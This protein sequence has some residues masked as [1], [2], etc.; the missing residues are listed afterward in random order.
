[1]HI[2][3]SSP[4]QIAQPYTNIQPLIYMYISLTSPGQ[5]AQPHIIDQ[6][7]SLANNYMLPRIESFNITESQNSFILNKSCISQNSI[8]NSTLQPLKLQPIPQFIATNLQPSIF[9]PQYM[10]IQPISIIY[11]YIQPQ[12]EIYSQYSIYCH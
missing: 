6:P 9:S 10:N 4:G 3:L 7:K 12:A 2:S 5:T 8:T 1:M 11:I